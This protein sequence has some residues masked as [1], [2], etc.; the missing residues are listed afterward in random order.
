MKSAAD[1]SIDV[2]GNMLEIS[3]LTDP[4]ASSF[5][6]SS[7][8]VDTTVRACSMALRFTHVVAVTLSLL[9]LFVLLVSFSGEWRY[10]RRHH[11]ELSQSYL[12]YQDNATGLALYCA[13]VA[14]D[15]SVLV[16]NA[17]LPTSQQTWIRCNAAERLAAKRRSL[18]EAYRESHGAD[19]GVFFKHI[20][21]AAGVWFCNAWAK[22][23]TPELL[24]PKSV[25]C[26]PD[27]RLY[28]FVPTAGTWDGIGLASSEGPLPD[29]VP[30]LPPPRAVYVVVL[31]HPIDRTMSSYY[32]FL[33][34]QNTKRKQRA[35]VDGLVPG[36]CRHY[37]VR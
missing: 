35:K 6:P 18:L 17:F 7:R 5:S 22:P 9:A 10:A 32:Y 2:Y 19:V 31:R 14:R 37:Y 15:E 11:T 4:R 21:K 33:K 26:I 12:T 8:A 30:L 34:V 25:N 23:N 3:R 16:D 13:S 36:E 24:R 20:H 1:R 28:C 29:V 27:E